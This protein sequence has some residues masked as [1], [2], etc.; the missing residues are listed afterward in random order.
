[1]P[2][3]NVR[4]LREESAR[5]VRGPGAACERLCHL[6]AHCGWCGHHTVLYKGRQR[7]VLRVHHRY[8]VWLVLV[9]W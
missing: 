2:P 1:M 5:A 3:D 7:R 6:D 8:A 9:C 4:S